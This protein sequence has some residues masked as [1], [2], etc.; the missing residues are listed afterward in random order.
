MPRA[1]RANFIRDSLSAW[2]AAS[3]GVTAR[4]NA[5]REKYWGHWHKYATEAGADPF[6]HPTHIPPLERDIIAGA[7][8]ARVRAG[9]FGHGRQLKVGSVSDALAAI[10]K[11]I[12]L[13]GQPSPLYRSD[14]KYHLF[15]E[16]VVEGYRRSD[17]PAIPQLA[18]PVSVATT[19]YNNAIESDDMARR[20]TGSLILVAFY[21]LLRV[22]E[23]TQPKYTMRQGKKVPATRTRQ[24]TVGNVGFFRN[25]RI[26]PRSSSLRTLLACDLVSLK[27]TNQ[28]NGRMGE[29]IAQHAIDGNACPVK[30]L[31]RIV[32]HI[33]SNGGTDSTLICSFFDN[34][35]WHSITSKDIVTAVR[36]TA[37]ILNL[38]AHGIDPDLIGAH[39]L[40]AGGA[41][42]LKLHGFDDTT[43][44][45]MGRWT[46]LTF[47]QYIHTQIAHLSKDI[48]KQMSMELPFF[49]IAAIENNA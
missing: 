16:R 32:H 4:T 6:L 25:G 21:F 41:M 45:K 5:E 29:T 1:A 47:L 8:A 17:P 30:A 19:A 24:F 15:L 48:S 22:G 40:R 42:A 18:V 27:I 13:A 7:F 3:F 23:Y 44:M 11:T 20:H 33:K 2:Q 9:E 31:A 37:K 39:S 46:S 35:K 36:H 10:S 34:N 49:N 26:V 38:Q 14:Q 43:I 12:E 28:K